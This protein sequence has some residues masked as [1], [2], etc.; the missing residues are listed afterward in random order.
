MDLTQAEA[1]YLC[2]CAAQALGWRAPTIAAALFTLSDQIQSGTMPAPD[3]TLYI[4]PVDPAPTQA[5][6]TCAAGYDT[7]GPRPDPAGA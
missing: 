6:D 2:R 1:V 7:S 3:A 4:S 5:P